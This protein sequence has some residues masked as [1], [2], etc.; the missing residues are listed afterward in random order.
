[1]CDISVILIVFHFDIS[2]KDFN[3]EQF[4]NKA[5]K[6]LTLVIFHLDMSGIQINDEQPENNELISISSFELNFHFDISGKDSNFTQL[7]NNESI[8]KRKLKIEKH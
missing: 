6:L 8:L 7:Q 4:S 3:D 1:M 5:K 2:G